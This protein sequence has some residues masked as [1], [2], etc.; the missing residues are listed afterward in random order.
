MA[1]QVYI[2]VRGV[3]CIVLF[4]GN[5][6][7]DHD[8]ESTQLIDQP[9]SP[10]P[11]DTGSDASDTVVW[12]EDDIS[13]HL[14][15]WLSWLRHRTNRTV[16]LCKCSGVADRLETRSSPACVTM[17][18]VFILGQ[19]VPNIIT[20]IYLPEESDS[21]WVHPFKIIGT[22]HGSIGYL[23]LP[24][25]VHSNHGSILYCFQAITR[26]WLKIANFPQ[27]ALFNALTE[28]SLVIIG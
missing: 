9:L 1:C 21:I 20:E 17:T 8:G 14:P 26:Y 13:K 15:R 4:S 24:I 7:H 2:S 5:Q 18:N 19:T 3:L 12:N 25:N 22:L 28:G 10:A 23:R 16:P 6:Q 11:S 27:A